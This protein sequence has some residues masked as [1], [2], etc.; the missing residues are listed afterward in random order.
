MS[1]REVLEALSGLMLG[2]VRRDPVLDGGLQRAADD[3]RRPRRQASPPTPGSS[4]PPCSALTATTPIW[5][6]L[7]DLYEQE[8]AGPDLAGH[9]RRSARSSPASPRTSGMLIG[10]RV[11]AGS[12]RRRSHRAGPD[13]DRRDRRPA[14][15]RP[16]QRL[17][18]R[19]VRR[20]DR[21]R[22]AIGG[23]IVDTPGSAGAG[24]STSASRSRSPPW[25]CCSGRCTCRVVAPEVTHRLRRRHADRRAACRLLLVWV[26]L[27]GNSLRT[28]PRWH[29]ALMV[30][31]GVAA[32][33]RRGR[34]GDPRRRAGHP[35]APVPRPHHRAGH[36]RRGDGRRRDVRG[37]RL[38]QPV[39]P[40]RPRH[41]ARPGPA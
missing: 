28:G 6:K 5:G 4:P 9:L 22:P 31:G 13:R 35:A 26:S 7:A 20:R 27:A 37:D 19:D 33:R 41:V 14:R 12:R 40:A 23:V 25:S 21:Q 38:P 34:R 10:A 29:T 18:R 39:L 8:A 2:H 16:L 15:A 30:A 11:R 36:R 32:A 17:P 3:R 1:H 24:A